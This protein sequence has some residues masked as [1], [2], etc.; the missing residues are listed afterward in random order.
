MSRLER[1]A[2][3]MEWG[4]AGAVTLF[5]LALHFNVWTYAGP[6]WR[7]EISSLSLA[8]KPTLHE[9]WASLTFDPVPALFFAILRLWHSAGW[10]GTDHELRALG[11]LIGIGTIVAVWCTSWSLKK[12]PPMW[13]LILFGLSPVAFVWGDSLRAYGL[14]CICSIATIGFLWTLLCPRPRP[15]HVAATAV[16]ALC[17]VQA[18]FP[19]A[20]LLFA[21]GTS[22]I[23]IAL[24]RRWFVSALTIA[25]IGLA[26]ALSLLPY[27]PTMRR[28]QD[29]SMIC[30]SDIAFSHIASMIYRAVSVGGRLGTAVWIG[31]T[32]ILVGL[33]L[34]TI[35]RPTLL[36][37]DEAKRN[38]AFYIGGTLLVSLFSVLCFFWTVGWTTSIW[39]Y[40]P[41]MGSAAVCLDGVSRLLPQRATLKAANAL[42][43]LLA[44]ASLAPVAIQASHVRLTNMDLTAKAVAQSAQADDLVVLD[45]FF[46]SVSFQRYY[47]GAAPCLPV[48]GITDASLH[49]WDLLKNCMKEPAQAR[50]IQSQIEHTLQSG[51]KVFVVGFAIRNFADSL[52]DDLP[53]APL[54]RTGWMVSPYLIRWTQQ[55]AYIVQAH[56]TS[57]HLLQVPCDQ[58]VSEGERVNALYVTG[59]KPGGIAA[60]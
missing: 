9:F 48:P 7:D 57:G 2:R 28:T 54:S 46:Y 44:A 13:A 20:L 58:P 55:V 14:S 41:L 51:H 30:R 31:L 36:E 8:T 34:I 16:A 25:G 35:V 38:L 60:K 40:L 12:S 17:S 32:L 50:A 53:P 5:I 19:N 1:G 37:L 26:A 10:G 52:P 4:V 47:H 42:L 33:W 45:N 3:A 39:Y 29:W 24:W 6:L 15:W 22:A 56:A 18:L 49:R 59:W 21:A 43:V 23:L 27:V 11:C